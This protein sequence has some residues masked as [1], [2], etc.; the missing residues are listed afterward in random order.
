MNLRQGTDLLCLPFINLPYIC[1]KVLCRTMHEHGIFL[2][3]KN[4]G[5]HLSFVSPPP[6]PAL[7][8]KI[9]GG[10]GKKGKDY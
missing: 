7:E 2:I 8:Q 5:H 9:S 1:L 6:F 4:N 10:G 3:F